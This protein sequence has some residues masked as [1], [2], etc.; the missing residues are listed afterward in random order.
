MDTNA[1]IVCG[2]THVDLGWKK[3]REEME[4]I[5]ET[6]IIKLLDLCE[7]YPEYTHMLE[8]AYH[9]RG[10]KQRRPDL[11][12]RLVPLVRSGRLEFVTGLASTIENNVTCGESFVRNMQIGRRFLEENFGVKVRDCTM[13]DTFGFPP[14]MPQVLLQMGYSRLLANRLGAIRSQDVMRIVGLDGSKILLAG[15]DL[16]AYHVK[17]GH[18]NFRFFRS[19]AEQERLFRDAR[20]NAVPHQI[21]IPYSE[22]EVAPCKLVPQIVRSSKGEL[23]FGVLSEFFDALE[24]HM[25]D[26]PEVFADMNPEFTGTF[27]QRPL[28]RLQNRRAET[29][30]LDAEK[31]SALWKMDVRGRIEQC[32][33]S[34]AYAQF[35]DVITGSHPTAVYADCMQIFH[36][37]CQESLAMIAQ[38]V[39]ADGEGW[40]VWNGL[41]FERT[42]EVRIPLPDGWR[43][44]KAAALDGQP[45]AVRRG[46]NGEA[47]VRVRL[48]PLDAHSLELT[49]GSWP[50]AEAGGIAAL[51]NEFLRIEFDRS[52]M[53]A[54]V[55]CKAS[56]RTVLK[57]VRDLLVFQKDDGNFQIEQPV[58]SEIGCSVGEYTHRLERVGHTGVAWIQ[59]RIPDPNGE[60][61][62]YRIALRLPDG[63]PALGVDVQVNWK[64][65]AARLRLKLDACMDAS[66]NAYEVPFGVTWRKSY[67]QRFNSRGEWPAY[68]FVCMEEPRER[69]GLALINCGTAGVEACDGVLYTTLLRAPAQEYAGMVP[70]ETSSEHGVRNFHFLLMPYENGWQDSGVIEMA[71]RFND[72]PVLLKGRC[73]R[74]KNGIALKGKGVV[75]SAI[76]A[77]A[78]G[79]VAVRVYETCGREAAASLVL[80][81]GCA[82][83][84]SDLNELRGDPLALSGETLPLSLRPYE[85]KTVLLSLP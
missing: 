21:I 29:L 39:C 56:G 47:V 80:P 60:A 17:P 19:Y 5:F 3:S 79:D 2:L 23:R 28:L 15:S 74:G 53:I 44:A 61:V 7:Q 43:G 52:S 85:I 31:V 16:L 84:A 13:I 14:Q 48:R 8:Q 77:T 58:Q 45:V 69:W 51:E 50:E 27:S 63:E 75:L 72:P 30:L 38:A 25:E 37:V 40:T 22:N 35:H 11:F 10:L 4:E 1:K 33:W 9:Y 34:L 82:A 66:V 57:D 81:R 20:D 46:E 12:E 64:S 62:E 68:R 59:G 26:Y 49:E 41:P 24:E 18:I 76:T 32:W 70:D 36:R 67:A 54:S 73:A 65:E 83:W 42:E 55:I 71:Q 78:G 6:F